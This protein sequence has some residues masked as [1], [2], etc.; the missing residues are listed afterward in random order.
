[1]K[2]KNYYAKISQ[3][4]FER[5]EQY[6]DKTMPSNEVAIFE[7]EM[8]N[9]E[10]LRNE[11][12]LQQKLQ[13]TIA[14]SAMAE[15]QFNTKQTT[16]KKATIKYFKH[17]G[18]AAAITA[19]IAVP[20][21]L[22]FFKQVDLYDKYYQSDAG[23]PTV[24]GVTDNYH[25]QDAMVDYKMEDYTQAKQ[26]WD[27][28]ALQKP[29][30]DTLNYYRAMADLNLENYQT[31]ES[32]LSNIPKSSVFY[33]NGLWYKALIEIK[34]KNHEEAKK[35]LSQINTEQAKELLNELKDK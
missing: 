27:E 20:A 11:V 26:K 25:F 34:L 6:L 31:A 30:N 10:L 29:K 8:E 22:L 4:V 3:K 21:Y 5:I 32:L 2:T 13:A 17:Y 12:E 1:M 28:L 16:T 23:L 15:E 18:I 9:D 33:K 19:L 14:V 24:M 7:K 35:L